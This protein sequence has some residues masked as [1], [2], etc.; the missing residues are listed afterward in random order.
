MPITAKLVYINKIQRNAIIEALKRAQ[1]HPDSTQEEIDEFQCVLYEFK[2]K[3]EKHTA[4]HLRKNI[5][6]EGETNA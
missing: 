4:R 2:L 6:K 1:T 3:F 5:F